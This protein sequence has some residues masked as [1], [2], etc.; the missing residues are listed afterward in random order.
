MGDLAGA[1]VLATKILEAYDSRSLEPEEWLEGEWPV[2]GGERL[3]VRQGV[4]P[5]VGI[6]R[7]YDD[8]RNGPVPWADVP[9]DWGLLRRQ[10]GA[11]LL[12]T[13]QEAR[14]GLREERN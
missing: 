10:G 3:C 7:L 9:F 13:I 5:G 4:I 11:A 8:V 6:C 2:R 14:A 1:G 12:R